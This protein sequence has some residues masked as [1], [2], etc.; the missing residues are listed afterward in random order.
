MDNRNVNKPNINKTK[1]NKRNSAKSQSDFI[2]F[3]VLTGFAGLLILLLMFGIFFSMMNSDD[4]KD[5]NKESK[6]TNR[7]E[8]NMDE[9][10]LED[11]ET[12]EIEKITAVVSKEAEGNVIEIINVSTGE[13]IILNIEIGTELKDVYGEAMTLKEFKLGDIIQTKFDKGSRVP[14]YFR[15]SGEGWEKSGVKNF[16]I[17][18]ELKTIEIGSNVYSYT[19]KV[20]TMNKNGLISINDIS[21]KDRLTIKGYQDKIWYINVEKSH[22]F[23]KI[24]A[25]DEEE[26]TVEI[27]NHISMS[28]E[29]AKEIELEEGQHKI[30]IKIEGYEPLVKNIEIEA[31]Q[32]YVIDLKDMKKK[33][34]K[35]QV[36]AKGLTDYK[37]Y[38]DDV[39]YPANEVILLE[40]GEYNLIV[41]KEGYKDWT[42]KFK[43]Q[44]EMNRIEL[45]LEKEA[46]ANLVRMLVDTE[47]QGA[48]VYING[49]Y[50]GLSPVETQLPYGQY[51]ISIKKEGY[52][53]FDFPVNLEE[54]RKERQFLFTLQEDDSTIGGD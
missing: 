27:G 44:Q 23:I 17:D 6:N 24:N 46:T 33:V 4:K 14:E 2:K 50:I 16:K 10:S 26:G 15:I 12:G 38:I 11:A 39:E 42:K 37:I 28:L 41:R 32:S 1:T 19:D 21:S 52:S 18:K 43:I 20:I 53:T 40:Y 51:N 8:I 49:A 5:K 54:G 36:I 45:E 47:P 48:E 29:E 30:V 3:M 22:G 25:S 31:G 13:G 35:L 34:G 7:Q 9:T